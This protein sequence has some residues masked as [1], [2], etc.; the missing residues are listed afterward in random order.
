MLIGA[1]PLYTSVAKQQHRRIPI[2]QARHRHRTHRVTKREHLKKTNT[3]AT[4]ND[5]V[6]P[7]ATCGRRASNSTPKQ[8]RAKQN[9]QANDKNN[10]QRRRR[11]K[12]QTNAEIS[13]QP[14]SEGADED[15]Y[16]TAVPRQPTISFTT[17]P[18]ALSIQ[19]T[20]PLGCCFF[21]H[22]P[23]SRRRRKPLR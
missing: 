19:V 23:A 22:L 21:H 15:L 14:A 7:G 5:V 12:K 9:K 4:S 20:L 11:K 3:L 2:G 8:T 1:V 6:N 13:I 18:G 10:Y 16:T 17:S